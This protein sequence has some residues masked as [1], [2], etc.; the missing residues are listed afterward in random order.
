MVAGKQSPS[1]LARASAA[2]STKL[3]PLPKLRIR[4]PDR[5]EANPCLGVMS[6]ML[7]TSEAIA[8]YQID[9]GCWAS[10]GQA[11]QACAVLEQ[12]LRVCM[13]A[14]KT[15]QT[16]KNNI[17]HYLSRYYPQIIGPHKRK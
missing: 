7:G 10:Q 13:D 2:A 16:K 8:Y 15:G 1:A 4:R 5:V 12:Q 3:P 9:G 11:A 14:R 17:N 6:S